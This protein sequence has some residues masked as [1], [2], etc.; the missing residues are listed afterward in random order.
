LEESPHSVVVKKTVGGLLAEAFDVSGSTAG[1]GQIIKP[2][3]PTNHKTLFSKM[4]L[5]SPSDVL[6]KG[7]TFLGIQ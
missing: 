1:A 5:L 4:V 2:R 7:L 6:K 3:K